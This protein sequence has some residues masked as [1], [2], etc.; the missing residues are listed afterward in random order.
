MSRVRALLSRCAGMFSRRRREQEFAA[1]IES[2]VQMQTDDNVRAGMSP[3]EAR[4]AA[5]V[6]L[7][8]VEQTRQAYRERA[9]L[10][11][12]ESIGQDLRFSL[13][14]L[15]KNPGFAHYRDCCAG[16]GHGSEHR[17]LRFR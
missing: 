1:E 15:V 10:P 16:P 14:Q 12:L 17:D 8:G 9:T 13:R 11:L 3:E 4:R 6:K 2:H 7:G 5:L